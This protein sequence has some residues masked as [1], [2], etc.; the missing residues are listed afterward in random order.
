[1]LLLPVAS[2]L[3][4]PL[5]S[6]LPLLLALLLPALPLLWWVVPSAPPSVVSLVELLEQ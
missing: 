1:L 2:L 3:L 6:L 5:A 4:A